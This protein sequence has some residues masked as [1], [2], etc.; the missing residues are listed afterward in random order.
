MGDVVD[1]DGREVPLDLEELEVPNL[2]FWMRDYACAP[3]RPGLRPRLRR[4]ARERMR[5]IA[6][7]LRALDPLGATLWG[8]AVA[9]DETVIPPAPAGQS[10]ALDCPYRGGASGT[11]INA[12]KS[13]PSQS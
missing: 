10:F 8:V 6:T 5:V 2:R 3:C 11:W 1:E 12:P 7:I 9:N 13:N 4:E